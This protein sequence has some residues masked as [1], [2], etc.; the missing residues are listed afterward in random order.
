MLS[1]VDSDKE[2]TSFHKQYVSRPK[3]QGYLTIRQPVEYMYPLRVSLPQN[4][5]LS[6]RDSNISK[7]GRVGPIHASIL[8]KM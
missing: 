8:T 5:C 1:W 2:N 7:N 3:P 4:K 6:T